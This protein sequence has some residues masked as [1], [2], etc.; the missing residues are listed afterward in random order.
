[1]ISLKK[2]NEINDMQI[3]YKNKTLNTGQDVIPKNIQDQ[4][5]EMHRKYAEELAHWRWINF[6]KY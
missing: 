3:H 5:N 2:M 6:R 1:M 4:L